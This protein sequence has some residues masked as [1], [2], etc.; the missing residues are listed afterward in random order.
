MNKSLNLSN[1]KIMCFCF[2]GLLLLVA[3]FL[4]VRAEQQ[5]LVVVS[6]DET[7][8]KQI[9]D[10]AVF[11]I[12]EDGLYQIIEGSTKFTLKTG[13][14]DFYV[15][16]HPHGSTSQ[17]Y[18]KLP[19]SLNSDPFF[20]WKDPKKT[21]YTNDTFFAKYKKSDVKKIMPETTCYDVYLYYNNDHLNSLIKT[22]YQ[23]K[24]F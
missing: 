3:F 14:Y 12:K 7:K 22:D 20:Q 17:Q 13:I 9:E 18:I 19:T 2:I 15:V 23:I 4:F 24:D 6:I 1:K 10:A 5:K 21:P 16:L 8:T 11:E